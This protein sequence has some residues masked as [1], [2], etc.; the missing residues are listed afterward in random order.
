MA[1]FG[2]FEVIDE[3]G[4]GGGG[5]V[6]RCRDAE[7]GATVALKAVPEQHPSSGD[8]QLVERLRREAESI[9]ALDHPNIV[10]FIEFGEGN[11]AVYFAMELVDGRTLEQALNNGERFSPS[12]AVRIVSGIAEALDFAHARG[13]VHRDVKPGNVMLTPDGGIR[14]MDFGTAKLLHRSNVQQLTMMGSMVGSAHYMAPEQVIES[15]VGSGTD[16]FAL[17]I[18][19]WEM[20]AGRKPFEADSVPAILFQIGNTDP[21]PL[22]GIRGDLSPTI[23]AVFARALAKTPEARYLSCG[24]FAS[25]LR[26]ALARSE[27]PKRTTRSTLYVVLAAACL[28][29]VMI[30]VILLLLLRR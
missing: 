13:I 5:V 16:Q 27:A 18:I 21:P 9:A 1:V 12:Q 11:G 10:R 29:A 8:R 22:S 25:D 15:G 2:R 23:D 7:S 26:A 24:E 17:A 30:V 6:Y 20:L 3:L 4:R 19:A 28:G 14:V